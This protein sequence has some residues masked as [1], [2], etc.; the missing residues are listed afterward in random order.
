MGLF[1]IRK[2][3]NSVSKTFRLPIELVKTLEDLAENYKISLNQ[4][5]IQSLEFAMDNLSSEESKKNARTKVV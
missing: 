1:K 5:I 4:L 2:G 3:Y